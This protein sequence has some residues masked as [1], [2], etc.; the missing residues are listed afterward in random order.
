MQTLKEKA[1]DSGER[2]Y[3]RNYD[4]HDKERNNAFKTE[5]QPQK[6]SLFY[7]DPNTL[8]ADGWKKLGLKDKTIA[9]IQKYVSKGGRF[10]KPDDLKNMWGLHE[11]EVEQMIPFVRIEQPLQSVSFEKK[12]FSPKVI[13]AIDVNQAD[14]AAYESLPGIG[15]GYAARI[16]K[17]R[18]RLGGFYNIEQVK[19]T[20]GL[21]DSVFQQIKTYLIISETNIQK[22]NINTAD[23]ETLKSHP[24]IRYQLANAIINF[25]NQHGNFASVEDI[26]KIM[27]ITDE[28][29]KKIAPYLAVQ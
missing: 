9:T 10:K 3:S 24:Y 6:L 25:R 4:D 15:P 21:P 12:E 23:F 5:Q 29:F 18:N 26:K 8:S 2:K 13:K 16:I 19:E 7:F 17:F 20:F 22:I 11:D 1:T 27:L 28:I 14:S